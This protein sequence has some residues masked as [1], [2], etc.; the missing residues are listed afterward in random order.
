MD[1]TYYY[2]LWGDI[3]AICGLGKQISAFTAVSFNSYASANNDLRSNVY[4]FVMDPHF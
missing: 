4:S 2:T 3:N 1:W